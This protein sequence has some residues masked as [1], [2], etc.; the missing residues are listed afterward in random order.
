M[1]SLVW[2]DTAIVKA[3]IKYH[4]INNRWPKS[5]DWWYANKGRWPSFTTVCKRELGWSGLLRAAKIKEDGYPMGILV[6][7]VKA[8]MV[9]GD[10]LFDV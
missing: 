2:D 5:R 1:A 8:E 9:E 10:I 4:K 6:T 7:K 3:M